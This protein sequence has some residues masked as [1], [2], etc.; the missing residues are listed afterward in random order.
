MTELDLGAA[1]LLGLFGSSHCLVMCGGLGAALGMGI[2]PGQRLRLLL[3]FQLGRVLSYSLLGAG[4]G[5]ALGWLN[6]LP[7]ALRVVSGLLLVSMGL[8]LASW[9]QGMLWLER[10]G[11]GLWRRI[12]PLGQRLLPLRRTRDAVLVGLYWGFL[13]CGLIYTALAWSATAA[14]AGQSALLMFCFGLGTV[15][16]MFSTGIAGEQLAA[17]LRRRGLKNFMAILMIGFG[18]WT[19]AVPV[20]HQLNGDEQVQHQH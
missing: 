4:L 12:Q 2:E 8:Y 5:A 13:P 11:Q 7:G 1:V 18:V 16:V 10:L 6:I 14:N 3:L 9:W 19:A 17:T 15:P 20:M